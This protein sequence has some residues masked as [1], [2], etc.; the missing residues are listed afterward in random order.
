VAE[1][2]FWNGE[3]KFLETIDQLLG[4]LTWRN[5]KTSVIIFV[6]NKEMTSVV[7]TAKSATMKHSN[8][9][10]ELPD[11]DISWFNNIF[12]LPIDKNKEIKLAVQ[13][14]HIP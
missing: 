13:L 1:C 6:R 9:V 10:R 4:Y 11:S 12:S 5:S 2:K 7:A 14:F 3:K 8:F